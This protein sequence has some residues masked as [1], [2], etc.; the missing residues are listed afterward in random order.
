MTN[1]PA[2]VLVV[3]D[4][5][6]I[7]TIVGLN[8]T[9]AGME[10]GEAANGQEALDQLASGDWDACILDLAMPQTDGMTALRQLRDESRLNDLVVVVLSATST[11]ARA[12]E[13]MEIGAHAHLT[14]PFSPA[15]VAGIIQELIDLSPDERDKRRRSMLERATEMER[16]GMTTV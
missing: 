11:P 12:I 2:K 1:D 13:G 10:T 5:P 16:L 15:A 14:K 7:R 6:D 9:L 3:D 8:L 4:D